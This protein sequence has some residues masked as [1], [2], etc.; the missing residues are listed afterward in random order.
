M[1]NKLPKTIISYMT[2]KLKRKPVMMEK[3]TFDLYAVVWAEVKNKIK[4]N[5]EKTK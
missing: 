3:K 1:I 5:E 4:P 2:C